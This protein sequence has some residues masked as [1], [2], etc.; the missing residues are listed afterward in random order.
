VPD[1]LVVEAEQGSRAI[2]GEVDVMLE[3]EVDDGVG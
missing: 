2:R 1:I 3:R